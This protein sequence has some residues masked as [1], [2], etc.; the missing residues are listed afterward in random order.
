MQ[1]ASARPA[2]TVYC[3]SARGAD[4]SHLAAASAFGRALAE[5][6]LN[7]VYGGGGIGLMGEIARSAQRHGAH[8]TGIITEQFLSLEQGWT[9]CDELIVVGSMRERKQ[10]LEDLGSAFAVLSGGLGT[11]EE[12]FE[13]LVGRVIG[14]HRKPIGILNTNGFAKPLRD[15][16]AHGVDEGFVRHAAL[17][18]LLMH[19]EPEGLVEQLARA[20]ASTDQLPHDPQRMLPMHGPHEGRV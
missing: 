10:R 13:T 2:V 6:N 9:G 17:D 1:D 18:L 12:F 4:G 8:V 20:I 7:L 11:W 15:L 16:I 19:D 3:A 5:A 14:R